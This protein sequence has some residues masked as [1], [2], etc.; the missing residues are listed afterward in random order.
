MIGNQ[1]SHA[2][3]TRLLTEEG[4]VVT[5]V[6]SRRGCVAI[7]LILAFITWPK[8]ESGNRYCDVRSESGNRHCDVRSES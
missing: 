8:N 5:Q 2:S 1:A 7:E 6:P 3:F 4:Q